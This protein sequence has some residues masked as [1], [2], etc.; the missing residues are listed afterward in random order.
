M[1]GFVKQLIDRTELFERILIVAN[2]V[3]VIK[4]RAQ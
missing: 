4:K 2:R 3:F 1:V